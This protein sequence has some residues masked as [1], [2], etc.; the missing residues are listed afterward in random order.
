MDYCL[1][2]L[3]IDTFFIIFSLYFCIRKILIFFFW[4]IYLV[5]CHCGYLPQILIIFNIFFWDYSISN[6]IIAKNKNAKS[7][8]LP[9]GF[10]VASMLFSHGY[11]FLPG[12]LNLVEQKA[13]KKT[14]EDVICCNVRGLRSSGVIMSS[15][16]WHW[17]LMSR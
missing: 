3:M 15:A 13:N 10:W 2:C 14:E 6:H 12:T 4:H 7:I 16:W 9:H 8:P 5:P 11:V 17:G 1:Y